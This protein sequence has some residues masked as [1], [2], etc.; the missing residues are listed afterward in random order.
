M[1]LNLEG[2]FNYAFLLAGMKIVLEIFSTLVRC[3]LDQGTGVV[4]CEVNCGGE[5]YW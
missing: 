2:K 1:E 3:T 5:V 4:Y